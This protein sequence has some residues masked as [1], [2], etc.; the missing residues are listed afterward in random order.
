MQMHARTLISPATA[1]IEIIILYN[2]LRWKRVEV[3]HDSSWLS[4]AIMDK[5]QTQKLGEG[6]I[7]GDW[8]GGTK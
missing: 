8:S 1:T 7:T 4:W 5:R 6:Q 2:P 3:R